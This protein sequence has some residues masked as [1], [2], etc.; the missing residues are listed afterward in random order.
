MTMRTALA[1]LCGLGLLG[2]SLFLALLL[3]WVKIDT[4]EDRTFCW[5]CDVLLGLLVAAGF[6]SVGGQSSRRTVLAVAVAAG[7]CLSGLF[8]L[9]HETQVRV[10][11]TLPPRLLALNRVRMAHFA[12][13]EYA[14][15]CDGFPPEGLGLTALHT[16]PGV[17]GWAGP[18]LKA[19]DLTDPWGNALQYRV[20]G[21]RAE[22][23]S[24]GP[25]GESG[26]ADDIRA[27]DAG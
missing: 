23:W 1:G 24:N 5:T 16:D 13:Q 2:V 22:V 15:D 3:L 17:P 25:D 6:L 14:R 26:T 21:G 19:E 7:V 8:L 12:L 10:R 20:T 27:D 18:Y 11:W 4:Q 9:W